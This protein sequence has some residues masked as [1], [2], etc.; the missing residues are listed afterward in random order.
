MAN[1]SNSTGE[2]KAVALAVHDG[3]RRALWRDGI[4]ATVVAAGISAE[5]FASVRRCLGLAAV[6]LGRTP[7]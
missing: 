4:F 7:V 1:R 5:V 2:N 6:M 3:R